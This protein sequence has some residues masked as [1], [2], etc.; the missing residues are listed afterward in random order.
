MVHSRSPMPSRLTGLLAREHVDI[1]AL[2]PGCL[3]PSGAVDLRRFDEFR[4]RALRHLAIEEL[5]L[6]PAL[7][8]RLGRRPV[9]Q[10]GL[11]KDHAAIVAL[12]VPMPNPE[13]IRNLA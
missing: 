8:R 13:W 3:L 11:R 7:A 12:C 1:P 5:V 9:F 2:L 10:T 4:R 6:L